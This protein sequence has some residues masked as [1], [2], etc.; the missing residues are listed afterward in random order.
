M[1]AR[2]NRSRII[3]ATK[4]GHF[5]LTTL[6]DPRLD[7]QYLAQ[8]LDESLL[9]LKTD[10][11][12]LYWLH[13]DDP[14]RPVEDI[15]DSLQRFVRAGKIRWYGCSNWTLPRILAA[16]QAADREGWPGFVANQL[17]WSLA[18]F[19]P[20]ALTDRTLV[21]MDDETWTMHKESQLAAVPYSSQAGGYFQKLNTVG[22][23]GIQPSR[24]ALYDR[25]VNDRRYQLLLELKQQTGQTIDELVLGYLLAQPF[26]V[27]PIIGP[28]TA[29][30]L[31]ASMAA[32]NQRW[33][34]ALGEQLRLA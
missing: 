19:N 33:Q 18:D 4:G 26:P 28:R 11:I 13:R 25:P 24:L 17:L 32:G 31:R 1:A 15:L 14:Q 29:E 7:R 12:D 3:L 5:D 20:S 2:K 23:V 16:R 30:Q 27:F 22:K 34:P 8:D 10:T 6:A 9:A 21:G